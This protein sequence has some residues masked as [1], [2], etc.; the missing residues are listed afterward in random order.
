MQHIRRLRTFASLYALRDQP[1][2][3]GSSKNSATDIDG[4]EHKL[5]GA[6]EKACWCLF[7]RL[8]EVLPES[9][10]TSNKKRNKL[11]SS[12]WDGMPSSINEDTYTVALWKLIAEN[13]DILSYISSCFLSLFFPTYGSSVSQDLCVRRALVSVPSHPSRGHNPLDSD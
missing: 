1:G 2:D 8:E 3:E 13:I 9:L 7:E 6:I 5:H 11:E 4:F 12:L 10:L